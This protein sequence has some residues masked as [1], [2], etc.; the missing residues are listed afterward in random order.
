MPDVPLTAGPLSAAGPFP[1]LCSADFWAAG[2]CPPRPLLFRL[3]WSSSAVRAFDS[4]GAAIRVV[5]DNLRFCG[6]NL[7]PG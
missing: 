2:A 7:A 3:F 1:L 6:E 5:V 4:P